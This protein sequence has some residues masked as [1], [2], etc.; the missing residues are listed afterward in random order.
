MVSYVWWQ[1]SEKYKEKCPMLTVKHGHVTDMVWGCMK[2][3]QISPK[4]SA[5]QHVL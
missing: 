5:W 3:H 4:K 2:P 1:P